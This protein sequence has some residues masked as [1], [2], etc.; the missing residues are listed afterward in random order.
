MA[1]SSNNI[2]IINPNAGK[3]LGYRMAY[4]IESLF[5]QKGYVFDTKFTYGVKH[6][7]ELASQAVSD[8]YKTIIAVG[9]DGTINECVNGIGEAKG[10]KFGIVSIGTGN[11][12]IKA[13]NIPSEPEDAVDVIIKGKTKRVDI[14]KVESTYFVNGL[15]I[16]FDAQVAEDLYKIKRLKGFSAYM[17]SVMKNFF[18]FRNP[19]IEISFDGKTVKGKSMMVS[20]MLGQYLGGGFYLTPGAVI[21]DGKFDILSLGDFKIL[22][23]FFHLS[24]VTKGTHLR[25]KG[26][27]VYRADELTI[28]SKDNL[29]VHVDGELADI[30]TANFHVRLLKKHLNLIVA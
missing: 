30:N 1:K 29:N 15:G 3:G 13:V 8:G 9:G 23:R 27:K 24:K 20:V 21:D 5:K 22:Q 28:S 18:L 26:V 25:V 17:Y 4:K 6:A 16:G 2:L 11:D 14:G 19:E 12:Y 10:I 7:V